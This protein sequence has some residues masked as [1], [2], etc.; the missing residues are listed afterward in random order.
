MP[1]STVPRGIGGANIEV[2]PMAPLS[3]AQI[4]GADVR[5][6]D[7][8]GLQAIRDAVL[9]YSVVVL[10]DQVITPE[11]Q[12]SFMS[13]LY[14]LRPPGKLKNTFTLRDYPQITVV[15]NI[16][17]N[18]QPIG[19]ADAGLLQHSDTC[20]QRNPELFVSLYAVQLPVRDGVT[21]GDTVFISTAAAYD[22]L[23]DDEKRRVDRLEVVQSYGFH[24]DK[25][26]RLGLL[27]RRN[28]QEQRQVM[29]DVQQP[30]VRVHSITGRRCLY[31]N[32]S[33]S[34]RVVGM[35]PRDSEDLL[36]YLFAHLRRPE[37]SFTQHWRTR[38]FV[39]WDNSATQHL[40]T[41]DYGDIPRRLHRC[42]TFGPV[43]EGPGRNLNNSMSA[44][45]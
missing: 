25:M 37:F 16:V 39:V 27:T 21:L 13:R 3:G 15:S 44:H 41:F 12:L 8:R 30:L 1:K 32:E 2:A 10:R 38:D 18:G 31:V 36:E 43:P 20:F 5:R 35:S 7:E 17:E 14:P 28:T 34:A 11:E 24:L 22:A 9:R 4:T 33:F 40:A 26:Q 45:W 29:G 6:I 23:P 42:S 19:I